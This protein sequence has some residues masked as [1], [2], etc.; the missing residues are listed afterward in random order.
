MYSRTTRSKPGRRRSKTA[1]ARLSPLI[2]F[3]AQAITP[4]SFVWLIPASRSRN[5]LSTWVVQSQ[6]ISG[7]RRAIGILGFSTSTQ[8][9]AC[10]RK[11]EG[12]TGKGWGR[13]QDQFDFTH[14]E[15][16]KG[17]CKPGASVPLLSEFA[18]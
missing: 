16:T 18:F 10:F 4:S 14:V 12:I 11:E 8:I 17:G 2:P 15:A 13:D 6:V 5:S 7:H 9:A 1:C 3:R